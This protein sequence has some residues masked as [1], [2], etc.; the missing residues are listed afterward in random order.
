MK[1]LLVK[2]VFNHYRD[3]IYDCIVQEFIGSIPADVKEP[4][5]EFLKDRRV[6][7]EKFLSIQ[8]YNI[9]RAR[10]YAK[11]SQE[12]YDGCLVIIRAFLAAVSKTKTPI[13]TIVAPKEN[14]VDQTEKALS[15]ISEF[16]KI[17]ISGN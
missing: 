12:F 4:A 17:G 3:D 1:N 7:F 15:S 16:R 5:L 9:Q 2:F 11:K 10:I 8:A 14:T 13:D 6:L